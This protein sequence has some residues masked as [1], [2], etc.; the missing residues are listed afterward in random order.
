MR[1]YLFNLGLISAVLGVIGVIRQTQRG[2]RDWRLLLGWLTWGIGVAIAVGT[3]IEQAK[4][5]EDE[6]W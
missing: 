3:V 4:E 1:K 5:H 6:K 2:P